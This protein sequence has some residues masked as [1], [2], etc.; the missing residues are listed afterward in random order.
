MCVGL[1][2]CAVDAAELEAAAVRIPLQDA[3]PVEAAP[4]E[5]EVIEAI[6]AGPY[7]YLAVADDDGVRWVAGL[8]KGHEAGA[9]ARVTP[10]AETRDFASARTG[11]T[12]PV[13]VFSVLEDCGS[14]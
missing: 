5:A 3:T 13:L 7:R 8:D 12:F 9:C 6:D 1:A 11:R 14:P 2:A 4:Y 10:I